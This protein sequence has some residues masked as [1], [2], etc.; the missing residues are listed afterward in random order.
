MA[1]ISLS[2]LAK[3]LGMNYDTVKKHAQ[4]NKIIKGTDGL[5]DT[6]NKIN[7]SYIL[8]ENLKKGTRGAPKPRVIIPKPKKEPAK[9]VE[10]VE[11]KKALKPVK[12][13]V[14]NKKVNLPLPEKPKKV[15]VK[16][17]IVEK[18]TEAEKP[19]YVVPALTEEQR[20][21]ER[22]ELR[23]KIAEVDLKERESE[24][25]RMELERK[26]GNLLPVDLVE[27]VLSINM[28]SILNN[29]DLEIENKCN[30]WAVRF[31]AGRKEI[32]EMISK[33]RLFLKKTIEKAE[34]DAN[35]SLE[36]LIKEYS[37]RN[38]G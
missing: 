35:H 28:K 38:K 26:A 24:L 23:K 7:K 33:E 30:I 13:T 20:Q 1:I 31:G 4:R 18:K 19:V 22:L 32:V 2:E 5:I 3:S 15:P 10:V 36:L 25:K 6:E 8:T 17:E 9:S 14:V 21:Y 11:V 34:K 27:N 29:F 12:N 37:E 16:K